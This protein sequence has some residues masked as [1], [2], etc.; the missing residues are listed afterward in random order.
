MGELPAEQIAL[1]ATRDNYERFMTFITSHLLRGQITASERI[2]ILTACEELIINVTQ[3]AC[4]G[5]DGMLSITV[6]QTPRDVSITLVDDGIPFNPLERPDP[7][8][9]LP[10]WKRQP[11][12]LGIF[13][14]KNLMDTVEYAYR[15]NRNIVRITRR[16]SGKPRA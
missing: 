11:G 9:S 4:T 8:I 2:P 13:L 12:G 10:P 5:R 7:D 1:S 14:V 3:F 16:V 15:D 6:E